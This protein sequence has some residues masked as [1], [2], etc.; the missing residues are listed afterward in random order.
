MRVSHLALGLKR[1]AKCRPTG[2]QTVILNPP[3]VCTESWWIG[4]DREALA[5][6]V[7]SRTF[8]ASSKVMRAL[9][10]SGVAE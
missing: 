10:A 4:L 5:H 2:T 1:C 8:N 6:A 9:A 7:A 3:E